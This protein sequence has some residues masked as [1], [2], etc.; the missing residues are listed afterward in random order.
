MFL[1]LQDKRKT[2]SLLFGMVLF[3]T[4]SVWSREPEE[5][6]TD[7]FNKE[8]D[9]FIALSIE[10]GKREFHLIIS[11]NGLMSNFHS[12][13]LNQPPRFV[14]DIFKVVLKEPRRF[15]PIIHPDIEVI[16]LGVHQ[17]RVRLVFDFK[18]QSL[19]EC[20]ASIKGSQMHV[21]IRSLSPEEKSS[22][23][24]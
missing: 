2:V 13:F 8:A 22:Q 10:E 12:F 15:I 14:I 21:L 5:S 18:N 11:G 7:F 6:E 23:A 9:E 24:H 19:P 17:D 1:F 20:L 3:W 4:C 16:R